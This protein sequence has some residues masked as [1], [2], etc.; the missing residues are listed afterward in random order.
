MKLVN[1]PTGQGGLFR[2]KL[3]NMSDQNSKNQ[4]LNL[5][6]VYTVLSKAKFGELTGEKIISYITYKVDNSGVASS[7]DSGK[8]DLEEKSN[9]RQA[10]LNKY[11]DRANYHIIDELR[12]RN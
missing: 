12:I 4:N 5:I 11:K 3:L 1:R 2:S 8:I 10:I 6:T 7:I 9:F